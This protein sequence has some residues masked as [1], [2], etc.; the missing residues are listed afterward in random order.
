MN[1][2]KLNE[3]F[4]YIFYVVG[5]IQV[6]LLVLIVS[7]MFSGVSAA[8][9]NSSVGEMKDYTDLSQ[10]FAKIK[11]ILLICSIVMFFVN[12]GKENGEI[13]GYSIPLGAELIGFLGAGLF[14]IFIGISQAGLYMKA[15]NRLIKNSSSYNDVKRT[16]KKTIK[17][18]EWF[19]GDE[20]KR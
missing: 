16:N 7:Q 20:E 15:G 1:V 10:G 17:N 3:I 12:I 9:G 4:G 8:I 5:A 11:L 19:F 18:A 14:A 13:I 6:I 2:R